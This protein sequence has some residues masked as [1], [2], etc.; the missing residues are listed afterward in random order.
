MSKEKLDGLEAML[1]KTGSAEI[2]GGIV[3][4]ILALVDARVEGIFKEIEENSATEKMAYRDGGYVIRTIPES[5]FQAL[6]DK[7]LKKKEWGL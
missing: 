7:C 6:K 3:N 2:S 1:E 4:Q 5:T